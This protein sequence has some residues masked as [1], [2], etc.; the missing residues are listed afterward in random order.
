MATYALNPK[1]YKAC[2]SRVTPIQ[3]DEVK[4]GCFKCIDKMY[5]AINADTICF[6]WAKFATLRG[7]LDVAKMDVATMAQEDP[8]LWWNCHDQNFMTTTLAI[9]FLYQVSSS[10]AVEMNLST[11]SFVHSLKRNKL[12]HQESREAC[13][14]TWC[15]TPH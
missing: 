9:C 5:D 14:Y 15:F 12:Y 10:L 3:D 13:G 4:V 2:P 11:Y 1:W 7:Y 6:Q 8:I